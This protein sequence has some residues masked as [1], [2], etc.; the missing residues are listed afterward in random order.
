MSFPPRQSAMFATVLATVLLLACAATS[1]ATDSG[2]ATYGGEPAQ[3][4]GPGLHARSNAILGTSVRFAGR[5]TPNATMAVQSV[6]DKT[7]AW[8]TLATA[9][10]GADGNYVARWRADRAGVLQVRA[11]SAGTARV[12]ASSRG[13]VIRVTV[14]EQARATWYGPGFYGHRTACGLK[15]T[16]T[17][18]GVAHRTLPCGTRVALLY[19]GRSITVP[20][21]DRGPF[22][23]A[24]ADWDLTRAA[25]EKL[26]FDF[27]DTLGAVSLA[28]P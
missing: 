21:V 24:G 17:L 13:D 12:R 2:G 7:G 20:V 14:F 28:Q 8:V 10:A 4:G 5:T 23:G 19:H 1:S 26:G 11:V 27:T 6:D 22:G 16:R 25:A 3:T 15:L 9:Q 18:V